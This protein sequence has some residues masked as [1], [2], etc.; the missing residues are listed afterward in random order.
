M[1]RKGE[2][3]TKRT[4]RGNVPA[5]QGAQPQKGGEREEEKE[6]Q[7]KEKRERGRERESVVGGRGEEKGK[8]K[9]EMARKGECVTKRT[10]RGNV[11][12]LQGAQ[13]QKGGE[14]EEEKEEQRKEKRERG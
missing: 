14:R 2:C 8:G 1:A 6:E 5:L 10:E 9:R 11:P 7:R 13:P 4:E 12:A 3:V